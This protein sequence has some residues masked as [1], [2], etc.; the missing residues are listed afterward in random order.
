M[1]IFMEKYARRVDKAVIVHSK[2]MKDDGKILYLP[3][4]MTSLL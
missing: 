2:N 1:D 3:I 4:Y